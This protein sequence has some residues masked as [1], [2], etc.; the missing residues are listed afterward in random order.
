MRLPNNVAISGDMFSECS[1]LDT[2]VC[3]A[4]AFTNGVIDLSGYSAGNY[5]ERAFYQSVVKQVRLPEDVELSRYMFAVCHHLN[6]LVCGTDDFTNGVIDLSGYSA[7][8]YDEGVFSGSGVK[9]VRLPSG[10]MVSKEMFDSC[11]DLDTLVCGSGELISGVFDLSGYSVGSFGVWAFNSNNMKQLRLPGSVEI[12]ARLFSGCSSL[13]TLYFIG[14]GTP[15]IDG[16]PFGYMSSSG[17]I[18]YPEGETGYD[19][20]DDRFADT[21]VSGWTRIAYAQAEI[22]GQPVSCTVSEGENAEF[23][24]KT[25]DEGTLTYQWEASKDGVNWEKLSDDDTYGGTKESKLQVKKVKLAYNGYQYRCVVKN[26]LEDTA[27]SNA[28]KLQVKGAG[29]KTPVKTSKG[30][31]SKAVSAPKTRDNSILAI[32]LGMTALSLSVVSIC[33]WMFIK[34]RK[35]SMSK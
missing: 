14:S 28:A 34:R 10:T 16:D 11:Y 4:G 21:G 7:G 8:S 29:A 15:E 9:Q 35:E 33:I 2:M 5:G 17:T 26:I 31:A 18:Y 19:A 20:P 3:G 25:A 32:W 13:D 27:S 23:S 1:S 12:S 22:A 6:T 24:I 30:S